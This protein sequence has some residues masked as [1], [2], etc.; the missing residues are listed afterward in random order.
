M[1]LTT[2]KHLRKAHVKR[3]FTR[4]VARGYMAD[5]IR[6]IFNQMLTRIASRETSSLP[7]NEQEQPAPQVPIYFHLTYHPLDPPSSAVQKL[8]DKHVLKSASKNPYDPPLW[9]MRNGDHEEIG[10]NRLIVAYHRPLNLG[11]LLVPRKFDN[12]PGPSVSEMTTTLT[13]R[14]RLDDN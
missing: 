5:T 8:F 14:R 11:N 7:S 9:K 6:P 10:I 3:F 2:E 13:R 1:R 12:R 4:L